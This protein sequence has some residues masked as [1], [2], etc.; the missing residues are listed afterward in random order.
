MS[1]QYEVRVDG[2]QR[3]AGAVED[4]ARDFWLMVEDCPGCAI[5]LAGTDGVI[6]FVDEGGLAQ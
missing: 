6:D 1:K 2:E 3:F 4:L 5:D